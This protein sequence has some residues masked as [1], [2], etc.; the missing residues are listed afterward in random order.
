MLRALC[1]HFPQ[2]SYI[3]VGDTARLPYGTKSPE[4]VIRYA[5]GVTSKILEQQVKAIVVA[6]NTA[7]THAL[8]AVQ[9]MAGDLP[10][11]GMIDP[12]ADAAISAT[13]TGR[14][15]V[16]AT[17]GTV[18]SGI[19]ERALKAREPESVV[20]SVPCQML[21]ALA[22]E[23]WVEGDIP[24]ATLHR[25]LDPI[26]DS[27]KAPDTVIL[28]CTHFPVFSS[29]LHDILGSGVTLINSGEAASRHLA[30]YLEGHHLTQDEKPSVRFLVTD[31]PIR[32]AD[33]ALKF[34]DHRVEAAD[35]HLID[36]K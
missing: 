25:Y 35:V 17:V 21:V 1:G 8:H 6:C 31:D 19:Y 18:R 33:N 24:K 27:P 28:G 3:Y 10:V 15:G 32:F 30:P 14:I 20:F 2:E 36:I 12:A 13:K 5:E 11:I 4:T 9:A 23:G 22:E 29:L 16:M 26:F 34:F 7:S